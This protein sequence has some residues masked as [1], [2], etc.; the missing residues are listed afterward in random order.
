MHRTLTALIGLTL[1]L[2]STPAPAQSPSNSPSNPLLDRLAKT[3]GHAEKIRAAVQEKVTTEDLEV[4]AIVIPDAYVYSMA[5]AIETLVKSRYPEEL[6]GRKLRDL[7]REHKST[8]GKILIIVDI[9]TPGDAHYLIKEKTEVFRIDS[10]TNQRAKVAK[11][12]PKPRFTAWQ[13]F[14]YPP[15]KMRKTGSF[16]LA[17]IEKYRTFLTCNRI[18][19]KKKDPFTL[20][21]SNILKQSERLG[22]TNSIN[23]GNRQLSCGSIGSL[24]LPKMEM[25]FYP[26]SWK[27]PDPPTELREVLA[28]LKKVK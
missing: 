28:S 15:N 14:Q 2:A 1:L 24:I 20:Y 22:S 7:H 23:V 6:L 9:Q 21:V 16:K 4:R 8:M 10:G 13:V 25:T 12:E 11:E 19:V 5:V 3:V 17:E 18:N 27:V 26:G